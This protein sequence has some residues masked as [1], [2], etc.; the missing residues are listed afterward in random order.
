MPLNVNYTLS[1]KHLSAKAF[2]GE[3]K[4]KVFS[5]DEVPTAS[6][7][8]D[9]LK[10]SEML[11]ISLQEWMEIKDETME[12]FQLCSDGRW[13]HRELS[14]TVMQIWNARD[15]DGKVAIDKFMFGD[16]NS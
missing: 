10:L 7:P 6:L 3:F 9:D 4:L 8:N 5:W 1:R 11:R 13:Y 12:A 16:L 2:A 15:E 14:E